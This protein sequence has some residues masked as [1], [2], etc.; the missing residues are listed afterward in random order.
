M[1]IKYSEHA[2]NIGS[3][4]TAAW[5]WPVE[6]WLYLYFGLFMSLSL[7]SVQNFR[8]ETGNN[9]TDILHQ[10][11]SEFGDINIQP[12]ACL[13]FRIFPFFWA[14]LPFSQTTI[15]VDWK[16]LEKYLQKPQ[17]QGEEWSGR[18]CLSLSCIS[19]AGLSPLT[20]SCLRLTE[21]KRC[22]ETQILR[23]GSSV[24]RILNFRP[25]Q[26]P[27]SRLQ[28]DKET[29]TCFITLLLSHRTL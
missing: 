3:R 4:Q 14:R 10:D 13:C 24:I 7:L 26:Y 5:A 17:N 6:S 22:S 28:T 12:R 2:Q 11:G 27:Q 15:C 29:K 19:L 1:I 16:S 21:A 25:L 9:W 8:M 20:P 23:G 18:G